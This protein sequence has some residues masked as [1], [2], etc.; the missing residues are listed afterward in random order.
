MI[1]LL[2]HVLG[3]SVDDN[4]DS[5]GLSDLDFD[6]IV[7]SQCLDK[8]QRLPRNGLLLQGSKNDIFMCFKGTLQVS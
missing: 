8:S 3:H 2:Y 4:C 6:G 7:S 5:S 1:L